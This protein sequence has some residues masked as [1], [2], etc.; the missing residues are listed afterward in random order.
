MLDFEKV[1]RGIYNTNFFSIFI[2]GQF[3]AKLENLNKQDLG[4]FAHEYLHFIQNLTTLYGLKYGIFHF[5]RLGELKRFLESSSEI[6]LPINDDFMSN[7]IDEGKEVFDCLNG[8]PESNVEGYTSYEIN[9]VTKTCGKNTYEVVEISFYKGNELSKKVDF[10][11][12]C[13]KE[14]MAHY[15]QS[16]FDDELNHE[17]IPYKSAELLVRIINPQL[18]SDKRKIISLLL[19]SLSAI[20]PGHTFYKVL[21]ESKNYPE[22]NGY[23]LY[24]R[25]VKSHKV[26]ERKVTYLFNEYLLKSLNDF[27]QCLSTHTATELSHF[28]RLIEN[29][30]NNI[31]NNIVPI[32]YVLYDEELT[33][34]DKINALIDNYGIPSIRTND[35]ILHFPG[36]SVNQAPSTDIVDFLIQRVVLER[37]YEKGSLKTICSMVQI[38]QLSDENFVDHNCYENQWRRQKECPFTIISNDWGLKEK[39]KI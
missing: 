34:I 16:F 38:C 14:S 9:L 27:E 12:T 3:D 13:I 1:P 33:K 22:L 25:L 29:I 37:L 7:R 31:T 39:I 28:K 10:G 26:V 6:S 4:T 24:S 36:D 23:D 2:D 35:G 11:A 18:V 8:T 17:I 30:Q 20:N 21:I 15:F 5:Q 19:F 32:L